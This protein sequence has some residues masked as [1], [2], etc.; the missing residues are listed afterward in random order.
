M[1]TS[2][3]GRQVHAGGANSAIEP[4]DLDLVFEGFPI[5]AFDVF[6]E[7]AIGIMDAPGTGK[8]IFIAQLLSALARF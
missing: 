4:K 5:A 6:H 3:N 1:D 8:R 2:L 7:V